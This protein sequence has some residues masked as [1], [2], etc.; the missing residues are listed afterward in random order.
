M[1]YS[2]DWA[3]SRE[4]EQQAFEG[5]VDFVMA[6]WQKYPDFHI[7]H[8]APYEPAALKRLMGR[9]ASREE[10]IDRMLQAGSNHQVDFFFPR[11]LPTHEPLQR[12]R[13][14]PSKIAD[15]QVRLHPHR[16]THP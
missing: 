2:G 14:I 11:C 12:S 16:L 6:R 9:Y 15:V 10:E 7:Y 1:Q 4:R 3:M 5:L 8:F 13:L